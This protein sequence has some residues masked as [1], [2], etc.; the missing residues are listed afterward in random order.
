MIKALDAL[1]R[2][3]LWGAVDS[4][5]GAKCLV[6]WARVCRSKDEGGLGVR[7]LEV[8]NG[9]LLVKILHRLHT[10]EESS[11]TKWVWSETGAGS[12]LDR[13][14]GGDGGTH[15]A[16]LQ[17]LVPLY[18]S[19]TTVTVGNG[20][21]TSFWHDS[22]LPGGALAGSHGALFSH[23]MHGEASVAS[24]VAR[25]LDSIFGPRL[26][27]AGSRERGVVLQLICVVRLSSSIDSRTV[28][29]PCAGAKGSL[30]TS[31]F[32]KLCRLGGMSATFPEFVWGSW[33][34]TRVKFF[35]W[36]L[37]LSRIHTRD[38]LLKKTIITA[39]E[40]GC[41]CCPLPL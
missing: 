8:Q 29:G 16:A 41:P 32:Y 19:I 20:E 22:W 39:E 11:W 3:F 10:A 6:A 35:G 13:D 14:A 12:I 18:R 31:I 37:A 21:R 15:W 17:R 38:L 23:T 28:V 40:A 5:S 34:P 1:H 9:C 26:N 25:G 7:A 27:H 33:A 2:A 4:I 24:V 30:R 36:L